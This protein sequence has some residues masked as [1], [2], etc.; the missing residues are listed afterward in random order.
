M[1][2]A[3]FCRP[4]DGRHWTGSRQLQKIVWKSIAN[5]IKLQ[6]QLLQLPQPLLKF[7]NNSCNR[8]NKYCK[9]S[10]N[11]CNNCCKCCNNC[12]S[13]LSVQK[14]CDQS[15]LQNILWSQWSRRLSWLPPKLTPKI[16][17][18]STTALEWRPSNG[19]S[20]PAFRA[21]APFM[22]MHTPTRTGIANI[23]NQYKPKK[24][25]YGSWLHNIWNIFAT[26]LSY[27]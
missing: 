19:P 17:T 7:C 11:C 8:C 6:Q 22:N 24:P 14:Y 18:Q 2:G 1:T 23:T 20:E 4:S 3:I 9:N 15:V 10:C 13:L 25:V 26:C 21:T 27:V 16:D 12:C 5:A